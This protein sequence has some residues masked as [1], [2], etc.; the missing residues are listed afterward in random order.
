MGPAALHRNMAI[1]EG[2]SGIQALTSVHNDE[3]EVL[4]LEASLIEGV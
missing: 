3:L 4:A 1:D 2:K